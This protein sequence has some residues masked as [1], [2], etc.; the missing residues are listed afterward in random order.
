MNTL[1]SAP[2]MTRPEFL[3]TIAAGVIAPAA[4]RKR[5]ALVGTGHRGSGTWGKELISGYSDLVEVVGLC[6]VNAKRVEVARQMMNSSAPTF[7]SLDNMLSRTRPDMLIVTTRDAVHHEQIIRG[8]EGGCEVL[9]EKPMTVDE[10]KC[11]RI[12]DAERKTRGKLTVAF[13][14]RYSPTSTKMKDLLMNGAIGEVSSV[15]FHW[16]L[17]T[18]HGADYFRRWH[19]HRR[20]S[21]T[22]F[23]HKSTHHFDLVNWYLD[24]EPIE[25]YA[26]A[27]LRHYGRNGTPGGANCRACTRK[28]ACPYYWDINGN[29]RLKALYAD[30]ESEDGY[31]R[32]ACVFRDSIDI[33]D[34]MTAQ[35]RY[36][37]GA[38]LSYSVHTFMP[39]EGHHIA[40][41]GSKGRIELRQY[42]RQAWPMPQVDEI[43]LSRNFGPSE[44]IAIR[45]GEGGHFGGDPAL[46]ELLFHPERPDRYRQRAGSRAGA[47]SLL[48]GVAAV[49]SVERK[50]VVRIDSLVRL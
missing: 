26:M 4:S 38:L 7:T 21:N 1:I 23:L 42:E 17:D 18:Q 20:W 39:I 8:L 41:N 2:T 3:S 9:T 13:N 31:L 33:F 40:C 12:L 50:Q 16:Y 29:A 24:A 22:L 30:C 19:A 34:T 25:V 44:V 36:T 47:M 48:T 11:Q 43:R 14:Y 28:T 6:D 10:E 46:K 35:V 5:V 45:Q 49:R 27:D 15:D 32:D 37:N